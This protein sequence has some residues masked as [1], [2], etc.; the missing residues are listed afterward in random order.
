MDVRGQVVSVNLNV[1]I[2]KKAGG[3]YT[4]SQLA[5]R[6]S[7]NGKLEEQNFTSQTLKYNPSIGTALGNL[8]TGDNFVMVKEK[9][10][11]FW[12][13]KSITKAG[14]ATVAAS[15]PSNGKTYQP[16]AKEYKPSGGSTYSTAEER[17]QTQV[18]IVRQHSITSAINLLGVGA[19]A[20]VAVSKVLETAKEFENYVFGTSDTFL[21]KAGEFTDEVTLEE[22]YED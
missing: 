21:Q 16:Q 5:Y 22:S 15:E 20:P 12:N 14:E 10:G 19:K 1:E 9:E 4:G 6:N 7:A 18:Y 3:T 11:D 13:V 2:P 8:T 17:A